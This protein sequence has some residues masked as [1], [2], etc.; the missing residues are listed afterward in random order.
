[1]K[2]YINST[3]LLPL[4]MLVMG[5]DSEKSS[6]SSSYGCEMYIPSTNEY[7]CLDVSSSK[8]CNR[9]GV[10]EEFYADS[11]GELNLLFNMLPEDTD[12]IEKEIKENFYKSFSNYI[13]YLYY[14][15][16]SC[17][18]VGY[19][20][21]DTDFSDILI[22]NRSDFGIGTNSKMSSNSF[23]YTFTCKG[24]D[25]EYEIDQAETCPLERA[26]FKSESNCYSGLVTLETCIT[27][28]NCVGGIDDIS[29]ED[30][31]KQNASLISLTSTKK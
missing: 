10:I 11:N 5:C 19:T 28:Y 25:L 21:K 4:I 26:L 12:G 1:M 24:E 20:T 6:E 22:E 30:Y 15:D 27:Y 3:L 17:N 14:E 7:K 13:N 23:M 31:C 16:K 8:R 29:I 9:D 2:R 18:A